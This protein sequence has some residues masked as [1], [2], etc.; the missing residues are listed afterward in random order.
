MRSPCL[1]ANTLFLNEILYLSRIF[2]HIFLNLY[3]L[4]IRI[5]G[6]WSPKARKWFDGRKKFPEWSTEKPLIWM[7]CASLGE[8]EQG[9]P[10]LESIRKQYPGYA[11]ALS[12]FSPSG[13]EIRKNYPGADVVFYLPADSAENARRLLAMLDPKLVLWVKYEYWYYFLREIHQRRIPLLLISGIFRKSQPFFKVYGG[14][15]REML[16]FFS[17]LFV[18]N[19]KSVNLLNELHISHH[20]LAGDTR[21]DRVI[22]IAETALP[23]EPVERFIRRRKAVVAGSTWREDEIELFH[24]VRARKDIAFII[25]PHEISEQRIS[26]VLKEFPGAVRFSELADGKS[27]GADCHVLI[28]DNIGMLSFIYRYADVCF[29]GGGFS[30]NGV[31]NV[32]EAAVFGKPVIYGPEH[33]K[34]QETL[35]LLDCGGGFSPSGP[36]ELENI[37]TKL[38]ADEALI[39]KSGAASDN[40]VKSRRGA[41]KIILDY[42]QR[43]R[44][45]TN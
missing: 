42:I 12:F 37:L 20:Q 27:P 18:Q 34:F 29:V 25:A 6:L 17:E 38:F 35:D 44:L 33:E 45:L 8:F 24:F 13:Y 41:T 2:Y 10:V 23:I 21:F 5:A 7:H 22:D 30:G 36:L 4:G 1:T 40:Y 28:I 43:N 3:K 9:R 16:G 14:M 39:K 31:H 32:L 19:E 15:W 26:D 11:I